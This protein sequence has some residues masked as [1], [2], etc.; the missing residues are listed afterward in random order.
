MSDV[1]GT[2]L[3]ALS[4]FKDGGNLEIVEIQCEKD[5]QEETPV[6]YDEDSDYQNVSC[7]QVVDESGKSNVLD[8]LNMTL[9]KCYTAEGESYRLVTSNAQGNDSETVTCILSNEGDDQEQFMVVDE[10][11]IYLQA[12]YA[13][14]YENAEND[15]NDENYENAEND[16]NDENYENAEIY[17][18]NEN[19]ENN[20]K[21]E[22]NGN[23][24]NPKTATVNQP[25]SPQ[26]ILEKAKAYQQSKTLL[27]S[28]QRRQRKGRRRKGE[29]PPPHELLTSPTFKLYLYSCKMCNFKC[30]AIKELQV[31][32]AAEHIGGISY[33]GRNSTIALQCPKCPYR[34]HTHGQLSKHNTQSHVKRDTGVT[35]G[36]AINLD[37]DE[38]NAADVLV[39]GACG[40]ESPSKEVF[41]THIQKEHGAMAC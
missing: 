23:D 6:Q 41:R 31:H 16:K 32:R 24:R 11:N 1:E 36:E 3:E 25:P 12:E 21:S 5:L 19:N 8:L 7:M 10:N 30:N 28:L 22:T 38:V 33:R 26:W 2:S 35:Y 17:E 29:L 4:E 14:N 9:I 27:A 13:E 15:K 34:A 40:F 39:C 18:N 37:T 20:E